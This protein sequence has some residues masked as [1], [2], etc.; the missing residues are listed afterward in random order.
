MEELLEWM[1]IAEYYEAALQH[2]MQNGA[3]LFMLDFTNPILKIKTPSTYEKKIKWN[4]I[5]PE[6][7]YSAPDYIADVLI[8]GDSITQEYLDAICNIDYPMQTEKD[9]TVMSDIRS[10]YYQPF[11]VRV[12]EKDIRL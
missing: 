6:I 12:M 8:P 11:E 10:A 9:N 1:G 5:T 7:I 2:I 4:G 3:Q